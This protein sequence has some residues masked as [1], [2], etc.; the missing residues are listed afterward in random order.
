MLNILLI[1]VPAVR[2]HIMPPGGLRPLMRSWSRDTDFSLGPLHN[3]SLSLRLR[4]V[5]AVD[6]VEKDVI[7]CK[8]NIFKFVT[9]GNDK[10][11]GLPNQSC[12]ERTN[13]H[14]R[15]KFQNLDMKE[16]QNY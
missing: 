11:L 13:Q 9:S 14:D 15:F 6:N 5:S 3:L 4:A 10:V 7:T 16:K 8:V 1:P 2:S 12:R